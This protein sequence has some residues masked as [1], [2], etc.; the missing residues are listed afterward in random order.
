[1]KY[2]VPLWLFIFVLTVSFNSSAQEK[3][4]YT[5]VIHGG[6]GTFDKSFD[7]SLKEEY[8]NSLKEALSIGQKILESGGSSLDAV[9]KVVNFL[10]SDPKFNAGKGA[11][12]TSEGTHEL[13][14]SIMNGADLSC[15]AVAGVKHIKHPISLARM[16]MEKTK[17]VLLCGE[18]ADAFGKEMNM[19]Y[20]D[21]KYFDTPLRLKQYEKIKGSKH[22]TVGCVA[23]DTHGNLAAATSTGGTGYK[24]PGRVGDSPIIGAGTYAD[25]NTCAVSCTGEGELFIKNDIAFNL[26]ALM[27]YK[28][29]TLKDAAD[30][31]I[32]KRLKENTGG[33]IAV[34]KDGNLA[35][36][37]NTNGM[38]RGAANS[39]GL[40]EVDVWKK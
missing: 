23:L 1:M 3:G 5:I 4:K 11:V 19:D 24:M 29:L 28:N 2:A 32:Y 15:G 14:A 40:F 22:G 9:E 39:E 34:D 38:L 37:F 31:L 12:F 13:D 35:M 7:D 30:E 6:A 20:V 36:P 16:V 25:N 8:M 33:L 26:N 18:G 10:E 17:H 27:A 21:N